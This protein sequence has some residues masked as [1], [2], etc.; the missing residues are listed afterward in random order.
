M[1]RV[2]SAAWGRTLLLNDMLRLCAG[3]NWL[4]ST[5]PH[6]TTASFRIPRAVVA[7]TT[8]VCESVIRAPAL[9]RFLA[10]ETAG[11]FKKD[12]LRSIVLGSFHTLQV[13]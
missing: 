4:W 11:C 7:E 9:S 8:A 2:L 6:E 13:Q 1:E 5:A 10:R 12:M 3:N